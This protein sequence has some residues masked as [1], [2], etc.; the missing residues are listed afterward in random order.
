MNLGERVNKTLV[1][2]CDKLP[3]FK[4][5]NR[6]SLSVAKFFLNSYFKYAVGLVQ[7]NHISETPC[8]GFGFFILVM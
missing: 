4:I 6:V 7:Q 3:A 5:I 1:K 8:Y 2:L